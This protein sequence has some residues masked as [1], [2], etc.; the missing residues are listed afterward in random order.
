VLEIDLF[1]TR[2]ASTRFFELAKESAGLS[3]KDALE[4]F[5]VCV[6]LGFHGVFRFASRDQNDDE[7]GSHYLED[8]KLPRSREAWA[9]QIRA[10]LQLRQGRPPLMM[11]P[12]EGNYA[13]PLESKYFCIAAWLMVMVLSATL[14]ILAWYFLFI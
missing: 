3:N 13:P 14:F 7:K 4:V 1:S 10:S 5:Y 2:E 6:V 12:Q 9:R 11:A 8:L